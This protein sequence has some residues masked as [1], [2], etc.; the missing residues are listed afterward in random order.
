MPDSSCRMI[1]VLRATRA[2]NLVGRPSASSNEF[3]CSD[4]VPPNTAAIAS[5]VVRMMLLYGSWTTYNSHFTCYN[6]RLLKCR[7]QNAEQ[8]QILSDHPDL[9]QFHVG[10]NRNNIV[11]SSG[12][13]LNSESNDC[14]DIFHRRCTE[15]NTHSQFLSYIHEWCVNLN[16]NC[17]KYTQRTVNSDDAEIRYSLQLMT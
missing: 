8:T 1:W 13:I 5:M 10:G 11:I 16:K 4:C 17:S 2:L 6:I 15:K 9:C 14:Y 7:W 3:V 12:H